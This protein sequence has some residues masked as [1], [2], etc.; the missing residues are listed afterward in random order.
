MTREGASLGRSQ[1]APHSSA[2]SGPDRE[3]LLWGALESIPEAG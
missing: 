1:A 2:T 3:L